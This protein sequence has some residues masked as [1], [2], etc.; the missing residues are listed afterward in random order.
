MGGSN[1][2]VAQT[3]SHGVD[4]LLSDIDGLLPGIEYEK[5]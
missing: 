3:Y 2:S 1:S 4:S 5:R